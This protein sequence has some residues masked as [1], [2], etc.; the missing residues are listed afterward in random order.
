MKLPKR[1]NA[2]KGAGGIVKAELDQKEYK[3]F[4][5]SNGM[6]VLLI[7]DPDSE[8]SAA[9]L[10]VGVGSFLDPDAFKGTANY[11]QHMLM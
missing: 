9:S 1:S 6:K 5:M 3:E 7:S 8:V 4:K 2:R 11:L 10:E